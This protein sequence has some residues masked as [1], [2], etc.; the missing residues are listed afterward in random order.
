MHRLRQACL[1]GLAAA[2][3]SA[4]GGRHDASQHWLTALTPAQHD[5]YFPI[6][7]GAHANMSCNA[8]HGTTDTF[9]KYTCTTC[10]AHD[11]ATS[12]TQHVGLS[13]YVYKDTSCYGCHPQG[14]STFSLATHLQLFP[15]GP[16]TLHAGEACGDCHGDL[17][18]PTDKTKLLCGACHA[19]AQSVSD[20]IHN[21]PVDGSAG[22][23][24]LYTFSVAGCYACH[25]KNQTVLRATHSTKTYNGNNIAEGPHLQGSTCSNCHSST[26]FKG[27]N[28]APCHS[29]GGFAEQKTQAC[30]TAKGSPCTDQEKYQYFYK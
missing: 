29:P 4:C 2:V 5:T 17:K 18:H 8:C 23:G 12:D 6:T 9:K 21:S 7:T 16:N 10:H 28:C 1:L 27:Y 3:L 30:D 13:G 25:L 11:Q 14:K 15:I 26:A 22:V 24:T 19:H 20:P